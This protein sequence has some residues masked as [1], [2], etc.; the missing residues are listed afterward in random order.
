MHLQSRPDVRP[1]VATTALTRALEGHGEVLETP[2]PQI[3]IRSSTVNFVDYEVRFFIARQAN[4]VQASVKF[5]DLAFQH[6][7]S[8]GV[9]RSPVGLA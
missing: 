5:F 2:A 3:A 6:L 4:D 8:L 1:Y 7:D 9:S